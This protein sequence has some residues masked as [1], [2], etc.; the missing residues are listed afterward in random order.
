MYIKFCNFDFLLK[1]KMIYLPIRILFEFCPTLMKINLHLR[2][3]L[4]QCDFF[5][6]HTSSSILKFRLRVYFSVSACY[7]KLL[8]RQRVTEF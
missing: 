7:L 3:I 5:G 2:H 1:K 4:K 6:D 8:N